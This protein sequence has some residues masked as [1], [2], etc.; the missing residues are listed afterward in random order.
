M[1]KKVKKFSGAFRR[2][3]T[4]DHALRLP[5]G[6]N[7]S[8]KIYSFGIL[9]IRFGLMISLSRALVGKAQGCDIDFLRCSFALENCYRLSRAKCHLRKSG[10]APAFPIVSSGPNRIPHPLRI[11]ISQLSNLNTFNYYFISTET[12]KKL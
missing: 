1:A 3:D 4:P 12:L 9:A 2:R 7:V 6:R 8:A 5:R 10:R 11:T